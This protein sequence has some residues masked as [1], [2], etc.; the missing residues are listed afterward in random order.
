MN[1]SKELGIELAAYY[2]IEEILLYLLN[3]IS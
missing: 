3:A 2:G 1:N